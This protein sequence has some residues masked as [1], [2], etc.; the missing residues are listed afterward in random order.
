MQVAVKALQI[1]AVPDDAMTIRGFFIEAVRP[2][3]HALVK[4]EG[5]RVHQSGSFRAE[6]LRAVELTI[7]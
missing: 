5:A 7:L 1:A 6:Y 3:V 4:A 2:T